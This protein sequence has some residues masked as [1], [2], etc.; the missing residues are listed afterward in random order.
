MLLFKKIFSVLFKKERQ[1]ASSGH[2]VVLSG[3]VLIGT[4][5]GHSVVLTP[6]MVRDIAPHLVKFADEAER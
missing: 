6:N 1:P 4:E 5:D 2:V 3:A